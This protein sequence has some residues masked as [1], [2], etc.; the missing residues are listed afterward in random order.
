MRLYNPYFAIAIIAISIGCTYFQADLFL[1]DRQAL[2]NVEYWRLFSGHFTHLNHWHLLLNLLGWLVIFL[3]GA[4]YLATFTWVFLLIIYALSIS[5]LLYYFFPEITFYGGLSGLLH[6]FLTAVLLNWVA[7]GHQIAWLLL[8]AVAVKVIYEALY[9][10]SFL[11]NEL[12]GIA[13]VTEVHLLG[14]LVAVVLSLSITLWMW[15]SP[16]ILRLDR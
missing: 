12:M 7:R 16:E 8:S 1:Y 13:V 5:L 11:T 2:Q 3:L 4:R 15:V 10:Q 6:G 14:V 9:Q